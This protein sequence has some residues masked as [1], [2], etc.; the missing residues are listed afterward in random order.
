[1]EIVLSIGRRVIVDGSVRSGALARV[2]K[3][4]NR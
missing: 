1:M 4:L 3:V 2:I